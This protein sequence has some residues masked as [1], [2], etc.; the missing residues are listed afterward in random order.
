[1]KKKVALLIGSLRGGGAE[2]VMSNL[3]LNMSD[4]IE[5]YLYLYDG[6][7]IQYPYCGDLIDLELY[8]RDDE[9]WYLKGL[10]RK[11][12]YAIKYVKKFK[13]AKEK[14]DIQITISFLTNP[15]IVSILSGGNDKKIISERN[16]KSIQNK[17]DID[18]IFKKN[19]YA[20]IIRKT[21]K[22]ADAI[23]AV[24][25]GVKEDLKRNFGIQGD[26]IKVIYNPYSIEKIQSMM[27]EEIDDEYNFIFSNPVIINVGSL[28]YQK[29]QIHLIRAFSKV[30]ENNNDIK[31]VILG[32]G[33]LE[34]KLK[35]LAKELGLEDDIFFLGFQKNPFKYLN[36]SN[37]FVLTSL[38]EG[39]PNA[40]VEAMACGLPIISTDCRSGPREILSPDSDFNEEAIDIEYAPYGL[41]LPV[42]NEIHDPN[43]PLYPEEIKLAECMINLLKNDELCRKY[44][45]S[46]KK[47][48]EDFNMKSI[49]SQ[50]EELLTNLT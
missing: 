37:I 17:S 8:K 11:I 2:R 31:L 16:Y 5:K 41:L 49:I 45:I 30:K 40:L 50:W 32:T 23:V 4:N 27:K 47:R 22:H 1:M 46:A 20:S 29:G 7:D 19:I 44:S 18:S 28:S 12:Y 39:F 3:S 9:K 42:C 13:H 6:R 10:I 26:K 34:C 25:Q 36:N 48:A 38:Y 21:Y 14:N 15:N 33:K 35:K 24:S 43:E